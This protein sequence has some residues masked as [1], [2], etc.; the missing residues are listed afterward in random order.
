MYNGIMGTKSK[1][2][3]R[4]S[5]RTGRPTDCR[6]AVEVKIRVTPEM[7]ERIVNYSKEHKQTKAETVREALDTYL[8]DT[9]DK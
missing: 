8:P 7:D 6:K 1:G 9:K 5:P 3:A 2:G 4:V